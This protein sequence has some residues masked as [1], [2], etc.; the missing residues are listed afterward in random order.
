MSFSYPRTTVGEIFSINI[1][2]LKKQ[3]CF[4]RNKDKLRI[5][6]KR[7]G[8]PCAVMRVVC[9]KDNSLVYFGFT[10]NIIHK[11]RL[12]KTKCNLGGHRCWFV[13]PDCGERV[14]VLYTTSFRSFA[15]RKCMNL[16]YESCVRTKSK[17]ENFYRADEAQEKIDKLRILYYKG[18][19]TKKYKKL[20]QKIIKELY[21]VTVDDG[22]PI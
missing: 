14:G 20:Q 17:F 5:G 11:I 6:F 7:D 22:Y 19:P 4:T 1:S 18:K 21:G 15:C 2:Y 12:T 13:C 10:P 16:T 9:S 8:I 3:G